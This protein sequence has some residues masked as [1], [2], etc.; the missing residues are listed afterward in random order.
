MTTLYICGAGNP[1]GIRLALT[2]NNIQNRWDRIVILDDEPSKH[3][4]LILGVEIAGS[5]DI[6]KNAHQDEA[7]VSN[8][9]ARTTKRRQSA[10]QK[11]HCMLPC[12]LL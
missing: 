11:I 5:F 4:Q 12:P 6:L 2:I 7:E 3:G 10:L 9:V 1:E 8:M